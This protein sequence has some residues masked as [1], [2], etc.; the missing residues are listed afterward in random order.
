MTTHYSYG[1]RRG[2]TESSHQDLLFLGRE[3]N[4]YRNSSESEAGRENGFLKV[5][6][7]PCW[8]GLQK[9]SSGTVAL[10]VFKE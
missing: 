8:A 6:I 9:D 5:T 4:V 2:C 7:D 10:A 1:K 3:Q